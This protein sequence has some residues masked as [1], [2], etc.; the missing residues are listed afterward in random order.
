MYCNRRHPTLKLFLFIIRLKNIYIFFNVRR[1]WLLQNTFS[2]G[3]FFWLRLWQLDLKKIERECLIPNFSKCLSLFFFFFG[4]NMKPTFI[5]IIIE[6][7]FTFLIRVF[8][9]FYLYQII[10]YIIIKIK[11]TCRH[12]HEASVS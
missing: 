2:L 11:T 7:I 5:T 1:L 6:I 3:V 9:R 10:F 8:C 4:R 12:V